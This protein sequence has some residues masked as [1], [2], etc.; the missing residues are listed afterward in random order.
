MPSSS[1]LSVLYPEVTLDLE[2]LEDRAWGN[3]F[4][5]DIFAEYKLDPATLGEF[6]QD[7]KWDL[8]PVGELELDGR[9]R[10]GM[11]GSCMFDSLLTW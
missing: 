8:G 11:A 4:V 1:S 10:L 6:K 2:T 9:L 5:H 7:T 3:G